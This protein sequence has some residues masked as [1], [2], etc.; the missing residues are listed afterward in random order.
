MIGLVTGEE[1][2]NDTIAIFTNVWHV[3]RI[4]NK[5]LTLIIDLIAMEDDF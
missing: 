4:N 1:V 2:K 3:P 5:R